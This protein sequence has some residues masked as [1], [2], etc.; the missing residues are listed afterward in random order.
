MTEMLATMSL[1]DYSDR[2]KQ[3]RACQLINSLALL[4]ALFLA[5]QPSSRS[6]MV[7]YQLFCSRT[8]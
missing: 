3:R 2:L 1:Q 4:L 6:H 7:S 8:L 5:V